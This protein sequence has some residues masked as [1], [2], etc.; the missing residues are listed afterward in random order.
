MSV[1]SLLS[2]RV[3]QLAASFLVAT[4]RLEVSLKA[5]PSLTGVLRA[6]SGLSEANQTTSRHNLT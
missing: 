6:S 2:S 5:A 1:C 4:E 3:W